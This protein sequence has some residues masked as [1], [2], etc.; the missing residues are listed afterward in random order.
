[1]SRNV[2]S[3][4]IFQPWF[5][6]QILSKTPSTYRESGNETITFTT[7]I[8]GFSVDRAS[9][10][11]AKSFLSP[12]HAEIINGCFAKF[13]SPEVIPVSRVGPVVV[14]EL[15]HGP[16]G[17]FKDLSLAVVSRLTDH[18]LRKQ[19]KKVMVLVSTT[20][21][22]GSAAIH[23]VAGS[24][25]INLIVLY[26]RDRVTRVQ[27]LQMTTVNASNVRV[28]SVDGTGDELD[29]CVKKLFAD[30]EFVKKY[31]L[32]SLNSIN[33]G[34]IL[35]QAVHFVYLYLKACP[36]ADREVLFSVPSGGLGNM[37]GGYIAYTMGL[38]IKL[39]AAVNENDVV[40][41]A[42]DTCVFSLPEAVIQTYSSAMDIQK[43]YNIERLFYFLSGR[44][45]KLVKKIM[46]K[47]EKDGRCDLPSELLA[48]NKCIT[49]IKVSQED[50][51]ATMEY[52][53]KEF[54]Y[55]LCPHSAIGMRAA[56]DYQKKKERGSVVVIATA[57]PA[58]FPEV[59]VEKAGLPLHPSLSTFSELHSRKEAKLF[60]EEKDD[61][62]RI[63]RTA[64]VEVMS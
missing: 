45:C 31:N 29:D 4:R 44:N 58:K 35:L 64:V 55:L 30:A 23:S 36:A 52:V 26:P 6:S 60:M 3:C 42:F 14:G 49:T 5:R 33:V 11:S 9:D 20:G 34:R 17:A 22:T 13:D 32:V 18:F 19:E 10:A 62:E 61:W 63:L 28:Y 47:V 39:L 16:T 38:P 2:V 27:E 24:T 51:L 1:M 59:V 56:L 15:W 37:T 48:A 43:P 40:H 57:T 12:H 8:P 46:D 54:Q 41:R 7:A 50:T 21:D 53:M 25:N